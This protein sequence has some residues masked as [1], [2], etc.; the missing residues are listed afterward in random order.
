MYWKTHN[1]PKISPKTANSQKKF[2][3]KA[4]KRFIDAPWTRLRT[5]T[6]G[7]PIF[8]AEQDGDTHYHLNLV[9]DFLYLSISYL[10]LYVRCRFLNKCPFHKIRKSASISP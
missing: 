10:M 8:K 1:I 5:F 7:R 9:N 6:V 2:S 3:Q 4:L